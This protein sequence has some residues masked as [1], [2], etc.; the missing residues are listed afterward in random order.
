MKKIYLTLLLCIA[1]IAAHAEGAPKIDKGTILLL[2]FIAVSATVLIIWIITGICWHLLN[3]ITGKEKTF[4]IV[5]LINL[6]ICF[7]LAIVILTNENAPDWGP[8]LFAP[9]LGSLVGYAIS[10]VQKEDEAD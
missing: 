10:P 4:W 8:I 5:L 3:L 1:G 7:L 2:G 6:A 9:V